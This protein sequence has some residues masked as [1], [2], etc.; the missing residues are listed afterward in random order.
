MCLILV[1][2][3]ILDLPEFK[4]LKTGKGSTRCSLKPGCDFCHLKIDT[5]DTWSRSN[6]FLLNQH[7]NRYRYY[8][9][10]SELLH[11]AEHTGSEEH[12]ATQKVK[13]FS[14]K[15]APKSKKNNLCVTKLD[16][17]SVL[18]ITRS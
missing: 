6:S 15:N 12:L 11:H 3:Y 4:I 5:N 7:Q 10:L 8:P 1:T 16:T 9:F 14:G 17:S 18:M 2:F 13:F